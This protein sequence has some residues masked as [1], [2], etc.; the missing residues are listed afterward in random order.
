MSGPIGPGDVVECIKGFDTTRLHKPSIRV[1]GMPTL[2]I[3]GKLYRVTD[4]EYIASITGNVALR[5]REL[6]KWWWCAE[7]FRK[8][9]KGDDIFKL[10]EPRKVD[11]PP[12][13]KLEPVNLYDALK[14]SWNRLHD[15]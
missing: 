14:E 15:S 2:P 13:K 1:G 4:L 12:V 5:L 10:V 7:H 8:V 9:E 6:G 3:V 11:V